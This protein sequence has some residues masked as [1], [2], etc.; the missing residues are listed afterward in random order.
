MEKFL[1]ETTHTESVFSSF[2][3]IVCTC[4]PSPS[5]LLL[6]ILWAGRHSNPP[7]KEIISFIG[8]IHKLNPMIHSQPSRQH[9]V[10]FTELMEV[11]W[12]CFFGFYNMLNSTKNSKFMRGVHHTNFTSKLEYRQF[13]EKYCSHDFWDKS[14]ARLV[15]WKTQ[16]SRELY[17]KKFHQ[18]WLWGNKRLGGEKIMLSF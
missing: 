7:L 15:S 6:N 2:Y 16:S 11:V 5:C 10:V 14:D 3:K 9:K 17:W 1:F 8:R 12:K 18:L 4:L 13:F